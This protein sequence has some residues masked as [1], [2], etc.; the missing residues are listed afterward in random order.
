MHKF[1]DS[2]RCTATYRREGVSFSSLHWFKN[3]CRNDILHAHGL[4]VSY[5]RILRVTQGLSE[6]AIQLFEQDDAVI[7]GNLRKGLFTNGAK[8]NIDKNSRCTV[9]KSPYHGTSLSIFQ[10]PSVSNKGTEKSYEKYAKG[11]SSGSKKVKELPKF[12]TD[13]TEIKDP[14]E[15]FFSSVPTVNISDDMINSDEVMK[16]ARREE[17]QWLEH[18]TS[19]VQSVPDTSWSV[20]NARKST[21]RILQYFNSIL[22]LLRQNV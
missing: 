8:D 4:C 12:Y 1:N 19:L 20:Y 14:P 11:S 2:R 17:L 6:A 16:D 18:V 22:P 7:P 3:I 21:S 13:F 9:S 5:Q 15:T 10:F